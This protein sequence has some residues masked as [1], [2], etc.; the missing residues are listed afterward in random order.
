MQLTYTTPDGRIKFE[1][2]AANVKDAFMKVG[3]LQEAFESDTICGLCQSP[4]IKLEMRHAQDYVF[5]ELRCNECTARL[6]FGQ[7]KM[8]GGL[9]AKRR[10]YPDSKGWYIYQGE[11][12]DQREE[13]DQRR[14][15]ADSQYHDQRNDGPPPPP[16]MRSQPRGAPL[17]PPRGNAPIA[18]G[19]TNDDVPF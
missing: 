15:P 2:E 13:F 19:I 10:D 11:G 4:H 12:G 7:A 3:M 1:F 17:P 8:G 9:F 5:Y 14:P 18:Q 16:P 6:E